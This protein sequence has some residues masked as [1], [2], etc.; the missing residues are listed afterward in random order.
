M[1]GHGI[2]HASTVRWL[3]RR[4]S[5]SQPGGFRF[6]AY[7]AFWFHSNATQ[8]AWKADRQCATLRSIHGFLEFDGVAIQKAPGSSSPRIGRSPRVLGKSAAAASIKPPDAF[9]ANAKLLRE[10]AFAA[11]RRVV[12][13]VEFAER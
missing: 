8:P 3:T 12:E 7:L 4:L 2:A 11:T 1:W 13:L 5:E 9:S 10:L 6:L